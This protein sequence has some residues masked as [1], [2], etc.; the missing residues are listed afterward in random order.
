MNEQDREAAKALTLLSY[1]L[2]IGE[3]D[4]GEV[5]EALHAVLNTPEKPKEMYK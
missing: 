2:L 3:V 1:R 4:F 5:V